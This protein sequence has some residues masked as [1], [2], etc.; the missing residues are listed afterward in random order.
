MRQVDW[1][2]CV[3]FVG[4]TISL[5]ETG[6]AVYE[7]NGKKALWKLGET[8]VGGAMDALTVVSVGTSAIAT[9]SA[10]TAAKVAVS[11]AAKNVA[12]A[13]FVRGVGT[14]LAGKEAEKC[15]GSGGGGG[16]GDRSW[17]KEKSTHEMELDNEGY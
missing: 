2:K 14:T 13:T 5:F 8:V 16:G 9:T 4:T 12:G 17:K 10:K 15:V 6:K 7:G 3:P 1:I 11:A